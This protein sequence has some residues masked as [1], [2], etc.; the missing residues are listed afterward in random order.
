VLAYHQGWSREELAARFQRPVATIKT[1]LRRSLM[2][3]REC[4]D[5]A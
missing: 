2:T 5:A 4:L 1:I 3:L